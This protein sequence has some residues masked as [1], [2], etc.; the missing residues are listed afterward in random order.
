MDIYLS[1]TSKNKKI[2]YTFKSSL[3]VFFTWLYTN[4]NSSSLS[5]LSI[6]PKT[7]ISLSSIANFL[8]P[9]IIAVA[10]SIIRFLRP[11]F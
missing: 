5:F 2:I 7:A 10:H 8:I 6:L 3:I 9:F 4:L 1:N 11:Y